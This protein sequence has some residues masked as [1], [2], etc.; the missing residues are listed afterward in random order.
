M[1]KLGAAQPSS[2]DTYEEGIRQLVAMFPQGWGTIATADEVQRSERWEVAFQQVAMNPPHGLRQRT[3]L[4]HHHSRLGFRRRPEP[5]V[6]DT[7]PLPHCSADLP[8]DKR[9]KQL[10]N[11]MGV[12]L[13]TSLQVGRRGAVRC[14]QAAAGE[15]EPQPETQGL[16]GQG[17]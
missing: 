3:L 17:L 4:G 7:G 2:L 15:Q 1:I 11:L 9:P 6:G 8:G 16:Q 12:F 5:L 10:Q 14:A 13:R